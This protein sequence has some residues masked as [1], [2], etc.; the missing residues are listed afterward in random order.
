[1]LMQSNLPVRPLLF[2]DMKLFFSTGQITTSETSHNQ[3][4]LT[5]DHHSE[6]VG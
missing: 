1:M 5:V 4:P 2:H 3:L 6:H